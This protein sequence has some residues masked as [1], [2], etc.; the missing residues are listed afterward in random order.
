MLS[1][2]GGLVFGSE[3]WWVVESW[4]MF[5]ALDA[6]SEGRGWPWML[7]S[8]GG[9]VFRSEGWCFEYLFKFRAC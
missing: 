7:G 8:K 9:V 1:P 2:R 3:E 4:P 6:G 5:G